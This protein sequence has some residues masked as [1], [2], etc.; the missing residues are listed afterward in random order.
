VD[1]NHHP[2]SHS[3]LAT[4]QRPLGGGAG[5]NLLRKLDVHTKLAAVVF[6]YRHNLI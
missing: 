5:Q 6:A 3:L 4:D 2:P 1:P